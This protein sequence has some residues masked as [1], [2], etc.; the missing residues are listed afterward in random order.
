[1]S[2]ASSIILSDVKTVVGTSFTSSFGETSEFVVVFAGSSSAASFSSLTVDGVALPPSQAAHESVTFDRSLAMWVIPEGL[3][4]GSHTLSVSGSPE[5]VQMVVVPFA[6][7]RLTE[8]SQD[9]QT[10]VG[11]STI[12]L[13]SEEGSDFFTLMAWSC[14]KGEATVFPAGATSLYNDDA[15]ATN[16]RL[17]VAAIPPG[18]SAAFSNGGWPIV[19]AGVRLSLGLEDSRVVWPK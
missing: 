9:L 14:R 17:A 4:S 7:A 8:A 1:M 10:L 16:V 2:I 11:A 15:S 19:S 12:E 18:T 13:F 5:N 6:E 3:S